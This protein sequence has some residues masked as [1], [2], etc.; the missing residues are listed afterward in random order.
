VAQTVL[1][2]ARQSKVFTNH[3]EFVSR[4]R[5]NEPPGHVP[6]LAKPRCEIWL[7][8]HDSSCTFGFRAFDFNK[9]SNKIN[10]APIKAFDFRVTESSECSDWQRT[11]SVTPL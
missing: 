3:V 7:N 5:W 2:P 4:I 9:S 8:L 1:R 11:K 10:L 6:V